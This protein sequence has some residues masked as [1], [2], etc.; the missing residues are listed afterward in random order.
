VCTSPCALVASPLFF[1]LLFSLPFL[2]V[3]TKRSGCWWTVNWSVQLAFYG[4]VDEGP[5]WGAVP[6]RTLGVTSSR[7]K[8]VSRI[9]EADGTRRSV[10]HRARSRTAAAAASSQRWLASAFPDPSRGHSAS[11]WRG[12][13]IHDAV[14]ETDMAQGS[15]WCRRR[16][17]LRTFRNLLR[18]NV[19]HAA[20]PTPQC[21]RLSFRRRIASTNSSRPNR[22][23]RP[24][25]SA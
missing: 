18:S 21:L 1:R 20:R 24:P 10:C 8:R 11:A 7:A 23:H 6:P 17:K 15:D 3:K 16:L 19:M 13:R 25:S 4:R 9:P 12:H 14:V 5:G 2:C 22:T